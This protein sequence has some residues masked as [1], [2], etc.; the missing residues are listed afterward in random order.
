MGSE[1]NCHR[2][3]MRRLQSGELQLGVSK[4]AGVSSGSIAF[5][6]FWTSFPFIVTAAYVGML[7][8]LQYPW[9]WWVL[10]SLVVFGLGVVIRRNRGMAKARQLAESNA[11]SFMTLW[12]EGALS[13]HILASDRHSDGV[14]CQSPSGDYKKFIAH[15]F[16]LSSGKEGRSAQ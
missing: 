15:H 7:W 13:L 14:Y 10:G 9:L 5:S 3:I 8:V 1:E 2:E 12:G 6:G 4:M 11:L 16:L